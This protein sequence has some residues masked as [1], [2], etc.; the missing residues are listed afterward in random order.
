MKEMPFKV[1]VPDV[2]SVEQ[3]QELF[4]VEY[5]GE[6]KVIRAHDYDA[7][8]EIPGLYEYLF[9]K[10]YK[11]DSPNVVCSLLQK[12]VE[13]SSTEMSGLKVIDLG[14][15]NGM[16]GEQLVQSGVDTVMGIDIIEE[17]ADATE[18]DRPG[19]YEDYFVEDITRLPESV[20]NKIENVTPNCMTVVAALGFDDMPP[21]AFADGYNLITTPG[22]VAFNIKDQFLDDNTSGFSKLI[23]QASE[24]GIL[25]MKA[26]KHYRHRFCQD[27]TPLQY[28]A[29]VG[30]K[31]DNIPGNW[32]QH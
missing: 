32:V 12:T 8:Y 17:A 5:K 6:Q 16:V 13:K 21:Q 25:E 29:I 2:N 20:E 3:G 26:K 24:E 19:V 7:I 22:W 4:F 11:C 28:Y 10:M 31:R 30:E 15:G 27:G 14:A 1:R 9:Y 18:R 23:N